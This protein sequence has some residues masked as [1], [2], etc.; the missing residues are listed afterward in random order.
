MY[1]FKLSWTLS[2]KPKYHIKSM[3]HEEAIRLVLEFVPW[4]T[5]STMQ[6]S[7]WNLSVAAHC[8]QEDLDQI[9]TT[10]LLTVSSPDIVPQLLLPVDTQQWCWLEDFGSTKDPSRFRHPFVGWVLTPASP[11]AYLS[12]PGAQLCHGTGLSWL[13]RQKPS[14]PLVH[15]LWIFRLAFLL[16][17]VESPSSGIWLYEHRAPDMK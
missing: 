7:Y 16:L 15:I 5:E 9:P 10:S 13:C 17:W 8:L 14:L 11:P 3:N 2:E 6:V 4:T 12:T 1:L